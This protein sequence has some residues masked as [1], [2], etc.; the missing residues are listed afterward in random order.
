MCT[1]RKYLVDW[2]GVSM[3][4]IMINDNDQPEHRN[5]SV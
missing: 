3:M 2:D 5:I 1:I 4:M